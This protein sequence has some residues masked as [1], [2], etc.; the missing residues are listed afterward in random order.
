MPK[1]NA[2]QELWQ[3]AQDAGEAHE[4]ELATLVAPLAREGAER[5]ADGDR[6]HQ[7]QR[8]CARRQLH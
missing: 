4:R 5:Q 3:G 6:E 8:E 1:M 2:S 7:D